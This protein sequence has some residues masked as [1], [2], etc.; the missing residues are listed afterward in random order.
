MTFT[1]RAYA[2]DAAPHHDNDLLED[3]VDNFVEA[4]ALARK[5]TAETPQDTGYATIIDNELFGRMG[6]CGVV[7]SYVK[8][9]GGTRVR[10]RYLRERYRDQLPGGKE[11]QARSRVT[12]NEACA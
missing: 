9:H 7:A 11:H 8:T 2:Y 4:V 5:R 3:T 10:R 6:D 12:C 1:I